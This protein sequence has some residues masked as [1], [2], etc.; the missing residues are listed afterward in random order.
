M[1]NGEGYSWK[2]LLQEKTHH[3]KPMNILALL[4]AL[5]SQ[6]TCTM[7]RGMRNI[8]Q[9]PHHRARP[10]LFAGRKIL[11]AAKAAHYRPP[12]SFSDM[13]LI[14]LVF[15]PEIAQFQLRVQPAPVVRTAWLVAAR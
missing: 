10:H 11:V 2:I 5:N 1:I 12:Q 8:I 6:L 4:Q 15:T 9:V 14:D 3:E 7:M 13:A